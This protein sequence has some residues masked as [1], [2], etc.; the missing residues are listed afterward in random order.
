MFDGLSQH[1]LRVC[2]CVRACARVCIA[3]ACVRVFACW[4]VCCRPSARRALC[5]RSP[6]LPDGPPRRLHLLEG[7]RRPITWLVVHDTL[8]FTS[9]YDFTVRVW[10]IVAGGPAVHTYTFPGAALRLLA[11]RRRVGAG[12]LVVSTCTE[13][14]LRAFSGDG[15][16]VVG[17][18]EAAHAAAILCVEACPCSAKIVTGCRDGCVGVWLVEQREAPVPG[19]VCVEF[20]PLATL[21]G[22]TRWITSVAIDH[23]RVLS[24]S[25]EGL[26]LWSFADEDAPG[27]G[28]VYEMLPMW[29]L[30]PPGTVVFHGRRRLTDA[31][32]LTTQ[33][34][35]VT[36]GRPR[37]EAA[38][39]MD[40]IIAAGKAR[41]WKAKCDGK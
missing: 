3:R 20:V 26:R 21:R 37:G 7:H 1:G 40:D 9:S 31:A 34:V 19:G 4:F 14:S 36:E 16:A 39:S 8:A 35:V 24:A 17:V 5:V 15:S 18:R 28:G 29:V 41:F 22:H 30:P 23:Y 10:D 13:G 11:L 33:A 12:I 38:R 27:T 2:E 32:P 25:M 6:C